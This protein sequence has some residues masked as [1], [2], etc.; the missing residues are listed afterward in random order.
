MRGKSGDDKGEVTNLK[1]VKESSLGGQI[2][3]RQVIRLVGDRVRF[4]IA[5][6][7]VEIRVRFR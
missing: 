4:E 6:S 1:K 2:E 5:K 7:R 3:Q